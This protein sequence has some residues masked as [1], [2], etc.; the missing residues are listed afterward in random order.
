[1]NTSNIFRITE[2]TILLGTDYIGFGKYFVYALKR[3]K[4][5][6][7]ILMIN[8]LYKN[9]P[10]EEDENLKKVSNSTKEELRFIIKILSGSIMVPFLYAIT[11][12]IILIKNGEK[13]TS[14]PVYY[15]FETNNWP[16]F[17]SLYIIHNYAAFAIFV[18]YTSESLFEAFVNITCSRFNILL[19]SFKRDLNEI[20]KKGAPKNI[21]RSSI[22]YQKKIYK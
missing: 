16:A 7:I 4:M 21:F 18:S 9:S 5:K 13:V 1:M 6:K 10:I 11:P 8:D 14:Y 2:A 17:I 3:K 20:N 22:L 12:W 19:K 15:P